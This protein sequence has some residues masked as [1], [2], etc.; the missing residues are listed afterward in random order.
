MI[1][2]II[3]IAILLISAHS[4]SQA[5]NS[6]PYSLFG[7]GEQVNLKS[8]EEIAMGQMGGALNSEYQLSFTNP[9]SYSYLSWTTYVFAGGNKTNV[10]NDGNETQTS[11]AAALSYISLGIPIRGNQGLAFGLQLNTAVGYSL[12]GQT[13][14]DDGTITEID[15]YF[16]NGGTNRVFLGYG[17]KFPYNISLG[18]EMAYIFGSID[19]NVTNRRNNVQLATNQITD[20]N[21][22]GTTLKLGAHYAP[23]ISDKLK[24]KFGLAV[25]LESTLKENGDQILYTSI[26][27]ADGVGSPIDTLNTSSITATIKSPL[28]TVISA[29]IGQENKWF[30]GGE[31][32][33]QKPLEFSGGAYD[34]IDFYY[35]GDY[36]NISVGGF[37][38]PKMNSLS[39]YFERVTYRAGVNYKK[40]GLIV[41]NTEI[42]QYGISFGVGLPMG[43]KLSNVNLGFEM[44]K[45]GTT[46]NGLIEE[47]FYNFRLSLSLNDKWFRKQKIY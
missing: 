29:G 25:D 32:T 19:N 27:I 23:N 46:D 3:V 37:F 45:R 6:S 43:L 40:T 4:F 12:L 36:S 26:N 38:I 39:N 2:E 22:K 42:N 10:V 15:R 33:F 28:K 44:G 18:V 41:N 17:Y 1:K 24:L 30:F 34:D 16:G 9:A 5:T 47:N 20:S 31:Y 21:V 35:Y 13:F 8:V 11:S 7:I 14:D